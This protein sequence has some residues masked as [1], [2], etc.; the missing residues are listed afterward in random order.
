M[1]KSASSLASD[2]RQ[3]GA[4]YTPLHVAAA[5]VD[6]I[7]DLVPASGLTILEPSVGD[8]A[9]L[10]EMRQRWVDDRYTLV[11][12]DDNVIRRLRRKEKAEGGTNASFQAKDFLALAAGWIRKG[13]QTFDLI[14]GNP[15]FVRSRNLPEKL[16]SSMVS[17]AD[18]L[19]YPRPHLKNTWAAFLAASGRL[20]SP[21]GVIAF[22]LPYELITVAYGQEALRRLVGQFRRIDIYVSRERA[23]PEIDQDAIV[24]IAQKGGDEAQGVYMNRVAALSD[25]RRT[26]SQRLD[27]SHGAD[28]ALELNAYLLEADTVALFRRLRRS[29][30]RLDAYAGSAPGVV[31]AVNEF[32]ILR[33]E[34]IARLSLSDYALPILKK[35]SFASHRPEF[36]ER[37]FEVLSAR[38]PAYLL[39]IQGEKDSLPD[40]LV[41][42]LNSGEDRGFDQRYKC[43]NRKRWYEVPLVPKEPAFVFKRAHSYPRLCM[44]HADVYIT[45]T[46][47]GLR[48]KKGFAARALCFSFYTSLTMAFAEMDGR[49]YG[50]GVLEL[51]P[52]EFRG[53]PIVYHEPTDEEYEAF[54]RVHEDAR[55]D[56]VP[57]LDFGDEWLA[58]RLGLG[59]EGMT[60]LRGAWSTL[61]AHRLRHS[62][63]P[64]DVG[65]S[66]ADVQSI[67]INHKLRAIG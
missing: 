5:I 32:F 31:S 21:N 27:L 13:D 14:V 1:A 8:G 24:L 34:E 67:E 28:K 22:V 51:S 58:P 55:G 47:Y 57:L 62:G 53:L 26:S 36:T 6:R 4:V 46:A 63:R 25:L 61:R 35:G 60:K 20:L 18:I 15:P 48:I 56:P 41:T 2:I 29:C 39:S 23:F 33:G 45:D 66:E 42:Y 12:I 50:G 30:D 43:R 64:R 16:K 40:S 17:V 65:L 11:D 9:F 3:T 38:D 10:R 44:N 52:T 19:N 7:S 37:D 49:F 54:L 59:P